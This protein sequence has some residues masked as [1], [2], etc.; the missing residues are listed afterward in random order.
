MGGDE[1]VP[2]FDRFA[3]PPLWSSWDVMD[4][5]SRQALRPKAA[6]HP[7]PTAM[8]LTAHSVVT[9]HDPALPD[10]AGACA[11]SARQSK[12]PVGPS[13]RVCKCVCGVTGIGTHG[14]A[15]SAGAPA[16]ARLDQPPHTPRP[17]TVASRHASAV[18]PP[19]VLLHASPPAAVARSPTAAL[20][21]RSPPRP[22]TPATEA[23]RMSVAPP[24]APSERVVFP[25]PTDAGVRSAA[26]DLWHWGCAAAPA[27]HALRCRQA[28]CAY[29]FACSLQCKHRRQTVL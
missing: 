3:F 19:L 8:V 11:E 4:L 1:G 15:E 18:R 17:C 10:R 23:A 14:S 26:T 5:S 27:Q 29:P 6:F 13:W 7:D 9:T 21:W 2:P 24:G 12:H 22:P 25:R 16:A 28:S 20:P